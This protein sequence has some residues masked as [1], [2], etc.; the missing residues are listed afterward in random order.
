MNNSKF[1]Y[2][3][4]VGL[5]RKKNEDSFCAKPEIGVWVVA[6]GI[7]GN[8]AGEV[9]STI[10]V[11][12]IAR[13]V[14]KG[15]ALV[16]SIEQINTLILQKADSNPLLSGMATTIVAM[17]TEANHFEIAWVGDSRAYLWNGK[18][19]Q[20]LTTDHSYVQSLFDNGV[21][22]E[23]EMSDHPKR[24]ILT[25]ALGSENIIKVDFLRG[26]FNED[27]Q[28]L[29]CSDGLSGTLK[30]HEIFDILSN[31]QSEQVT[32]ERLIK[33]AKEN[34]SSDNI[35]AI[36]VSAPENMKLKT[37]DTTIP[38]QNKLNKILWGLIWIVASFI[39]LA[40][41]YNHYW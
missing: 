22:S 33:T 6:D 17:K 27:E 41:F 3:T 30:D 24:N 25:Q 10:A 20:Q 11:E 4:D 15:V 26:R 5:K 36:L 13:D 19:I 32:I 35:T 34:G 21:I 40:L 29:L 28:I 18:K 16:D 2:K 12:K 38:I 39:I 23:K 7:G 1:G 14:K 37:L 9:A 8:R 31:N